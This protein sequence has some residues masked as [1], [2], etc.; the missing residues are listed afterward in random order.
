M[1]RLGML[2]SYEF[3]FEDVLCVFGDRKWEIFYFEN[4]VSSH[5]DVCG[6]SYNIIDSEVFFECVFLC[7]LGCYVACI[8]R[9]QMS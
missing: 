5:S 4:I 8:N 9:R 2:Y 6:V 1:Q 7:C 3:V